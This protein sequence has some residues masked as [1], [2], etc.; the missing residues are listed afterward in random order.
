[1]SKNIDILTDAQKFAMSIRPKTGGFPVLAEV[2]RQAGVLVNRWSLPSCQSISLMKDG[3]VV[4]QGNPLVLGTYD[5][6]KF[7]REALIVAIRADQ[8]GKSSFPEFL[9]A[10]WKA[11]VIGYDVDFIVR[12]VT[13]YGANGENYQEEYPAVEVVR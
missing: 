12:K 9:E 3:A 4:Q 1:M 2:L 5:I 13:Y 10:A 7:D 8:Q 11:G 6:P